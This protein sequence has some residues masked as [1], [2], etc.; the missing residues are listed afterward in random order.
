MSLIGAR[1]PRT[2]AGPDRPKRLRSNERGRFF[3]VADGHDI[4]AV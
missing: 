4:A 2:D 3:F 1:S